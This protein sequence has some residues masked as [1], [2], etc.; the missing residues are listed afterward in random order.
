MPGFGARAAAP[1]NNV[2]DLECDAPVAFWSPRNEILPTG[3]VTDARAP[4]L[5]HSGATVTSRV[6]PE[7]ALLCLRASPFLSL[8]AGWLGAPAVAAAHALGRAVPGA[9]GGRPSCFALTPAAAG[10]HR[11]GLGA[12]RCPQDAV[13]SAERK[14]RPHKSWLA[15]AAASARFSTARP[16]RN[17]A[18]LS[19]SAGSPVQLS[20]HGTRGR[21]FPHGRP[22]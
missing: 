3:L 5:K 14:A 1:G 21:G 13:R 2:W 18:A 12:A 20:Q 19:L 7:A 6:A 4:S 10:G 8:W 17:R 22:D 15:R 9:G 11:W 16:E